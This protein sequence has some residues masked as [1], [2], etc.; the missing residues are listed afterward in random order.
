[1]FDA[2]RQIRPVA[3]GAGDVGIGFAPL[4]QIDFGKTLSTLWRGKWTIVVV[5]ARGA[6]AGARLH[7]TG[8]APIY[9]GDANPHRPD[10][11]A[12]RRQ[13]HDA[14][15]A[16]ERRRPAPGREPGARLGLGRRAAPRGHRGSIS[17]RIL[18]SPARDR[19]CAHWATIF[20]RVI[21]IRRDTLSDDRTLAAL[22]E[23]K[24]RVV[25]KRDERTYVVEVDVTTR[26]PEKSA[27]IANA[28][29]D[30][31]L[32]EQT[33]IRSDAARQVSQSLSGRL[34]DLR[35]SRARGRGKGRGL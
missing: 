22:S 27:R 18:N 35:G 6:G 9:G 19:R 5:G 4:A 12:R 11:S 10:R 2:P 20:L 23:L 13:W 17:T 34:K 8:A 14:V 26:D 25:V 33:Q 16:A 29:A 31:Y 28:I 32:A 1:M 24:R 30:A 21:G 7:R 15:G 3:V